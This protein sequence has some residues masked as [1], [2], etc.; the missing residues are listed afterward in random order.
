[1][2]SPILRYGC[3]VWAPF[4]TKGIGPEN[5][6]NICEKSIIEKI[7]NKFC[8]YLLGLQKKKSRRYFFEA[9]PMNTKN[10]PES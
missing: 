2:I 6:L 3:E 7:N 9:G 4:E 10:I 8:K 1:L 5:L